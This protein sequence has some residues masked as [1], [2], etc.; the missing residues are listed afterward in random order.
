[1]EC[2]EKGGGIREKPWSSQRQ[3]LGTLPSKPQPRGDIDYNKIT[4][5]TIFSEEIRIDGES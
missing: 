3:T 4:L 1:M 5:T 2:W